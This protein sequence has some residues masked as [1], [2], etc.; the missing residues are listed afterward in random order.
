M[1]SQVQPA[2]GYIPSYNV[3]RLISPQV[4]I[5]KSGATTN[6][7]ANALFNTNL[8][9][10]KAMAV[11]AVDWF[12][13]FTIGNTGPVP[14]HATGQLTLNL[15]AQLTEALA[16]LT[17]ALNDPTYISDYFDEIDM[18]QDQN[19]P[20]SVMAAFNRPKAHWQDRPRYPWLSVAQQF[21]IIGHI[22][23][24]GVQAAGKVNFQA[25]ISYELLDVTPQVSAYLSSRLQI[26][27]QA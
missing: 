15:I 22:G 24:D 20:G 19:T 17:P 12:V 13:T 25:I 21:N 10:G 1:S 6:G 27:G 7:D 3:F 26:T 4:T 14:G 16:R 11:T 8:P 18:S 23:G 9:L 5:D 2:S